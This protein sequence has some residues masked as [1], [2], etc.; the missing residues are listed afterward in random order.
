MG[1]ALKKLGLS[2]LLS[3]AIALPAAAVDLKGAYQAAIAY[4]AEL[5]AAKSSLEQYEEGV[6]VARA[7][8]LPQLSYSTQTNKADTNTNY[9]NYPARPNYD[10]GR[11]D[12][13]SSGLSFRQTLFRMPSWYALKGAKAQAEASEENYQ[14]EMQHAGLR[15]ASTYLE[16]LAAREGIALAKEQTKSMEAWLTLAEKYFKAGR[17]TRIDIEDARSRRDMAK[18]RQ[19]EANM[20]LFAAAKNFE[21]VSGIL[22]EKIPETNP[23][24]LNPDLMLVDNKEQWL[25]RIEDSSPEIQSL[26]KQLEAAKANVAQSWSGHLPTVDLVAAHQFGESDTVNTIGT[27]TTTGYVGVQVNIPL[28][29]GGGVMAQTRQAQAREEQIRQTLESTRRKTLAEGN[30]LYLAIYQGVEQVQA[31]NQAVLSA[32]QAVFGEK[33]AIQAGTRTLVDALDAERRLFESMRD[34]AVAI[35]SLANNRLKFLA[36]AGVVDIDAIETVSVW[37]VSAKI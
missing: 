2:L 26:R 30:R 1:Y 7:A 21:V 14:L 37:L 34:Q 12:S 27:A 15:V 24:K 28:L 11:Y 18:A 13:R 20:L 16:V 5:L 36:L 6:P 10:S 23:R 35:Y 33:K 29:S 4:D 9:L 22:A 32:E 31:L 3:S 25:Q 17:S 8:L 19:T